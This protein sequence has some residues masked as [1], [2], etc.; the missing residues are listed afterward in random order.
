MCEPATLAVTSMALTGFSGYVQG[1]AQR[2]QGNAKGAY[3]D[4]VAN[5]KDAEADY[6]ARTGEANAQL[7]QDQA[8]S[9]GKQLK[10][11]QAQLSA[12]QISQMVAQGMD[13]SSVSSQDIVASTKDTQL[14]DEIQLRRN[15]NL[16]EWQV[17]TDTN[18]RKWALKTEAEQARYSANQA[19]IAGKMSA[20]ATYLKTG[21]SMLG[22]AMTFGQSGAFSS[23]QG[24]SGWLSG[25]GA[26][27]PKNA[28]NM[29]TWTA[30]R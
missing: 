6:V 13:V 18:Y 19:R 15:A 14:L 23:T 4:Y 12:S 22:S 11:E 25:Y 7:I 1:R 3:Y 2:A 9:E 24:F 5:Q 10:L 8:K 27:T 28:V 29:G 30:L 16:Q 20:R 21:V 17:R 26:G